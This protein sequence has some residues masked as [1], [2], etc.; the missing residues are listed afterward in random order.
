[1]KE[2]TILLVDDDD[3]I[4]YFT[5]L[6]LEEGGY[7][8]ETAATGREAIE[9]AEQN[10]IDLALLDYRL[11]DI[12]GEELVYKLKSLHENLEVIFLTGYRSL[13]EDVP[14]P[15]SKMVLTKPITDEALLDA[16]KNVLP[17][18]SETFD[19]HVEG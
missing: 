9:K 3:N 15:E 14:L 5:R 10:D 7:R 6:I 4:L 1:M 16:I 11:P 8:V 13:D 17:E 2:V 18:V 19:H 12:T